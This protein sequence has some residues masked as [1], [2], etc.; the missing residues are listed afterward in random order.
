MDNVHARPLYLAFLDM[1]SLT[2]ELLS[3]DEGFFKSYIVFGYF[4]FSY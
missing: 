1:F 4:P 2:G 3:G